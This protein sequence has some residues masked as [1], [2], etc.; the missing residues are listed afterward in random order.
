MTDSHAPSP[1][2]RVRIDS[3]C[4]SSRD[5]RRHQDAFFGDLR[6]ELQ[7][8]TLVKRYVVG[9]PCAPFFMNQNAEGG[10]AGDPTG[11]FVFFIPERF[12]LAHFFSSFLPFFSLNFLFSLFVLRF[13]FFFFFDFFFAGLFFC[14]F[15]FFFFFFFLCFFVAP[16]A[17]R[18]T[19]ATVTFGLRALRHCQR[20]AIHHQRAEWVLYAIRP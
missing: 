14:F 7:R 16:V 1:I 5:T 19:A 2:V 20:V 15:F 8:G 11:G 6:E 4:P 13:F 18:H 9:R 3:C 10:R 17:F 12:L